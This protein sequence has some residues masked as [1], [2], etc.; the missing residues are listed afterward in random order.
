M[1]EH[2]GMMACAWRP[3]DLLLHMSLELIT[4]ICLRFEAICFCLQA[5]S[6]QQLQEFNFYYLPEGENSVVRKVMVPGFYGQ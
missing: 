3:S 5:R 6:S 2:I 4:V 1:A